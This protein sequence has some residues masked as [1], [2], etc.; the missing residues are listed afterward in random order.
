MKGWVN[1]EKAVQKGSFF[2]NL[3][4]A[5]FLAPIFAIHL[6]IALL[7]VLALAA[8][9]SA[10]DIIAK[11]GDFDVSGNLAVAG[12]A[13]VSGSLGIGT[14]TPSEK[15]EV[16]GRV[17][18]SEFCIAADCITDWA[19]AGGGGETGWVDDGAAVRLTTSADNVGIGTALPHSGL[20]ITK[21]NSDYKG[22]LVIMDPVN[23]GDTDASVVGISGYGNNGAPGTDVGRIWYLGSSSNTDKRLLIWNQL[24]GPLE[25]GTQAATRLI[26]DSIGRVGIATM[27]PAALLDI[28]GASS[29]TGLDKVGIVTDGGQI[30][31]GGNLSGSRK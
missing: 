2:Q 30:V 8:T 23:A 18:G 7:L 21:Q 13:T 26:V 14:T 27:N 20:H 12:G 4:K 11:A 9:V 16:V 5:R 6:A 3:I 24:A 1:K 25:L 29:L 17:K 22:Q 15:L 31:I 10:G 19:E 28:G